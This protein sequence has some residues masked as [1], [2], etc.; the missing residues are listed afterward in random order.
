M[1]YKSLGIRNLR[2]IEKLRAKLVRLSKPVKVSDNN[3]DTL[4]YYATELI[5]DVKLL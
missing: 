3:N 5:T 4:A 1:Y 2:K